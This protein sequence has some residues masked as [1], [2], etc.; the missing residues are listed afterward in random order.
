MHKTISESEYHIKYL[1][2]PI[3]RF[4]LFILALI[5]I[6]ASSY[7]QKLDTEDEAILSELINQYY[8][9][10]DPDLKEKVTDSILTLSRNAGDSLRMMTGYFLKT[11][12]YDD[13]R[14]LVYADSIIDFFK[15]APSL[16]QPAN[17][18]ITKGKYY[19]K[20]RKFKESLDAL[21]IAN[22]YTRTYEN[23][24]LRFSANYRIALLKERIG[25]VEEAKTIYLNNLDYLY[26]HN[27]TSSYLLSHYYALSN[28][29]REL[30][31]MDSSF[32]YIDKGFKEALA[33][34]NTYMSSLFFL[35]RGV[36]HCRNGDVEL[37]QKD[38]YK[39]IPH[40]LDRKELPN[41]AVA[42]YYLGETKI[43][44][45]QEEE[46]ILYFSK[47]DSIFT[48]TNDLLPQLRP[49]Y[50]HLITY[51]S[52]GH[53]RNDQKAFYYIKQ[54][55][56]LDS[57]ISSNTIYLNKNL[58]KKYDVPQLIAK[59]DELIESLSDT[60]T[61][62][63]DILYVV[64]ICALMATL[65]YVWDKRKWKKKYR[66]VLVSLEKQVQPKIPAKVIVKKEINLSP[67]IQRNI[68]TGLKQFEER[69]GY[70]KSDITTHL[71]AKVMNTNSKYLSQMVN[72]SYGYTFTDYINTLRIN[73]AVKRLK[74]DAKFRQYTI[75]AIAQEV[76]FSKADTFNRVFRKIAEIPFSQFMKQLHKENAL[77]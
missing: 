25:E 54:L 29:Y 33:Q 38:I 55:L 46:S 74:I 67:E 17:A 6:Q 28:C 75:K 64:G 57:T 49:A 12:L 68:L 21:I 56:K 23:E 65:Y 2:I 45:S 3:T 73:Y 77:S 76:G 35:G 70:L 69:E 43:K 39:S 51:Y 4:W 16:Y 8:I 50:E 36:N 31:K 71:L 52:E 18:Y 58:L 10:S 22:E 13:E 48:I 72:H 15:K 19:Y 14:V 53:L 24:N 47:V 7:S 1:M 66:A 42:Y 41:L 26:E 61:K 20:K 9:S 59:R 44:Q 40:L 30:G 63:T 5:S 62:K 27:K 60:N 37:G 32:Y 11:T 34:E